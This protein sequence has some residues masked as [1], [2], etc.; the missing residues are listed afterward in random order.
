MRSR[1]DLLRYQKHCLDCGIAF[2]ATPSNEHREDLRCP[3]GCAAA[4][5]AASARRRSA[6]YYRSEK[7]RAKKRALNRKRYLLSPSSSH[8]VTPS[9]PSDPVV[10]PSALL[11]LTGYLWVLIGLIEGRH[12][13]LEHIVSLVRAIWRQ[14][15]LPRRQRI[16]Y[17]IGQLSR[18]PPLRAGVAY[19]R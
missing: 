16:G 5:R 14:P 18:G 9:V 15:S 11:P 1:P 7:G 13:A 17:L 8:G 10:V 12:V 6:A 2:L 3:F 19:G 4:H